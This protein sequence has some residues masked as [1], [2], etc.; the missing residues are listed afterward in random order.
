MPAVMLSCL[1]S[2]VS[3]HTCLTQ[4]GGC[5]WNI[6]IKTDGTTLDS[7]LNQGASLSVGSPYV[8]G[9]PNNTYVQGL[10]AIAGCGG[11]MSL[12]VPTA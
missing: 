9:C 3:P 5:R 2:E 4:T 1:W 11:I 7:F 12:Q 6:F 8:T 10:T